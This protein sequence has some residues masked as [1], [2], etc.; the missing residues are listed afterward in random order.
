MTNI[1]ERAHGAQPGNKRI[2]KT[3]NLRTARDDAIAAVHESVHGTTRTCPGG[4]TTSA[5][6][7]GTDMPFKRAD[8]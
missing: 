5:V 1:F 2:A 6:G 7:G 3:P 4:P 8:F